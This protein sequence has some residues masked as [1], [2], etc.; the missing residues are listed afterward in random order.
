MNTIAPTTADRQQDPQRRSR[1][2]STQKL[3]S[4][5]V[6]CA[7]EAAHQRDRDRDAD[8]GGDEVLHRQPGHL[9]QVAHRGLARVGLPVRVG[10]EADRGVPGLR[11][12]DRRASPGVSHRCACT[13]WNSVQEQHRHRGERQHASGRTPPQRLLGVRVDPDQPVDD[14]LDPQVP[15]AGAAPG[16]C[17][18]RT[19]GTPRPARATSETMKMHARPRVGLIRN[20]PGTAGP[21]PGTPSATTARTRPTRF[22]ALTASPPPATTS[23]RSAEQRHG[24]QHE[25]HIRHRSSPLS[26]S[27]TCDRPIPGPDH[28]PR[29]GPAP[30]GAGRRPLHARRGPR[31]G[32]PGNR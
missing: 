19:A 6:L 16:T 4:W 26:S 3:P 1:T 17:S 20:A 23:H 21:P 10:D 2:R 22:A 12:L 8:R 24:Q 28:T 15:L 31:D 9:H 27:T 18:R 7:G 30:P 32:S 25:C 11:R 14:P 13:R 29:P 5:S